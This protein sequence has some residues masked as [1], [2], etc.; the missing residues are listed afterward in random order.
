MDR[1]LRGEGRWQEAIADALR[2]VPRPI[3]ADPRL[4]P[5]DA[6]GDA[7]RSR[8]DRSAFP[9]ARA[10]STLLLVYPADDG[11]LAIPLTVRHAA[12]RM[13]A[14]EV[15][16]PGGAVDESDASAEAAALREAHE[17]VGVEPSRVRIVGSL[18]RVWIP[19]SNFELQPFVGV[20]DRRPELRPHVAEV[21]SIV[22]LPLAHLL[23]ES[24]LSEEL[25]EGDGWRLRAGVYRYGG[26]R[27]WGATAR[28]LAMF[29]GAMQ[30]L[31]DDPSAAGADR[32]SDG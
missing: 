29:A 8:W 20:A 32:G 26:Q 3:P 27:I 15:S 11:S 18:D 10:A 4:A 7:S 24:S 31:P 19:V 21:A 30:L 9:P 13:H 17:E 28:I 16:L 12:M 14:G 2:R 25:I 1:I 22:E 6:S 23:A 5:R